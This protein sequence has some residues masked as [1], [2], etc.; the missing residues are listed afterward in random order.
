MPDWLKFPIV[1]II[2]T[3]ISAVALTFL[4]NLTAPASAAEAIRVKDAALKVVLPGAETFEDET[5][6]AGEK[7]IDYYKGEGADGKLIG[8]A[9]VGSAAGY[10][11]ILKIMVGVDKDYKIIAIKVLF[12]KE[13]PGLGDKVNEVLSKKTIVGMVSGKKYNEA[14]LRPW[15]QIQFNGKS[16]PVMVKKD[17]GEIE[18]ITG[19]TIS[20]RAVC[21]AVNEAVANLKLAL[22]K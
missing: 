12:Q 13:T 21:H 4:Q 16:S 5:A 15:F 9:T 22:K 14:G 8:Y 2:V 3:V 10:S 7:K 19:A 18:A 1:L 11:S 17:G 6:T 20:S